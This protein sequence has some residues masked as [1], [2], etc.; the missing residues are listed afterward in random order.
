MNGTNGIHGIDVAVIT[1]RNR[2]T[3]DPR[4][5]FYAH[6]LNDMGFVI[7]AL[8]QFLPEEYG[9]TFTL[10]NEN[11]P[12]YSEL[13][14]TTREKGGTLIHVC[15]HNHRE[16]PHLCII[17]K[18][19]EQ[20]GLKYGDTMLMRYEYGSIRMRKLPND[21][22]RVVTSHLSGKWLAELGFTPDEVLTVA[23]EPGMITCKLQENG[24]DRAAELVKYARQNKLQLIQV[25]PPSNNIDLPPSYLEK[26]GVLPTDAL[27]AT[28]EYGFIQLQKLD[29]VALGF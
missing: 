26:A 22:I 8:A 10:Y 20:T 28:C 3:N 18:Y 24:Q 16:D 14:R 21:M 19:L 29:F 11:I 27:L 9:M 6:W 25:R 7:G 17:G 12:K 2:A 15:R 23:A 13:L 4:L 5:A 1:R